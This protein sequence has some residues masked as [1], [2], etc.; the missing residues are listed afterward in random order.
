MLHQNKYFAESLAEVEAVL[1]R[2]GRPESEYV[3][4]PKWTDSA[5]EVVTQMAI[6][7]WEQTKAAMNRWDDLATVSRGTE[8]Q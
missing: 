1:R 5:Q 2:I 7:H 4:Y 3:F 8:K 6:R